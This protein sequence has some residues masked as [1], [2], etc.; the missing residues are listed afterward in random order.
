MPT[1]KKLPRTQIEPLIQQLDEEKK[2]EA[3]QKI[4]ELEQLLEENDSG[5]GDAG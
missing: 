1:W 2:K 3:E 4:D 5:D